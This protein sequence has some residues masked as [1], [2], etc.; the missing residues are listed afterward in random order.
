MDSGH[1]NETEWPNNTLL[2]Y[3]LPAD[4]QSEEERGRAC[5]SASLLRRNSALTSFRGMVPRRA[6]RPAEPCHYTG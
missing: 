3:T 2:T 4:W 5:G 6:A 1:S